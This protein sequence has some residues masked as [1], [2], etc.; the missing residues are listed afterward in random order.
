MR[1][2]ATR[3]KLQV[4]ACDLSEHAFLPAACLPDAHQPVGTCG[5][6]LDMLLSPPAPSCSGAGQSLR[7][8]EIV[9]GVERV[10]AYVA[11]VGDFDAACVNSDSSRPPVLYP[12]R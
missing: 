8:L 10:R 5:R 6:A 4:I 11:G 1:T 12:E 2:S 7:W 3:N 9:R